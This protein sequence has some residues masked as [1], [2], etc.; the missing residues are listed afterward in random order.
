MPIIRVETDIAAPPAVC[1]DLARSVEAHLQSAAGT[2]ERAVAGV[3]SGLLGPGDEVTWRAR[4]FWIEQELTSRIDAFDPP[5]HFRDVMV[6]GAFRRLSHDHF[7]EAMTSGTRMI[8]V[9]E[10]SAPWGMFGSVA[11]RLVLTSYLRRF[12]ERRA[13]V[14]RRLAEHPAG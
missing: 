9:V 12:L 6:R 1:F 7:F 10:F 2:H 13:E 11:E 5:R 8:D 4:H 14:L 3:T